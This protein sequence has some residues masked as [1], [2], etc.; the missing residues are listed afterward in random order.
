MRNYWAWQTSG[1]NRLYLELVLRWTELRISA[2]K[3]GS[4]NYTDHIMASS[5]EN[6]RKELAGII[7][8]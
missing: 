6:T 3:R 8:T 5:M 2:R 1:G 7:Y 4:G